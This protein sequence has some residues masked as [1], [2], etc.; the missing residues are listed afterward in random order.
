M[1][2]YREWRM[3]A[4]FAAIAQASVERAVIM[5]HRWHGQTVARIFPV[6]TIDIAPRWVH[7]RDSDMVSDGI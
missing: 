7:T 6:K 3:Y 5:A 1:A 4:D 2:P